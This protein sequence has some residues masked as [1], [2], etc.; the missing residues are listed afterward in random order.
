MNIFIHFK[1]AETLNVEEIID[2]LCE[3]SYNVS[4]EES[5]ENEGVS[6]GEN[7]RGDVGGGVLMDPNT[8]AIVFLK[9]KAIY[10][11]Q[12]LIRESWIWLEAIY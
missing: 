8:D 12:L 10:P 6:G 11:C 4:G 1:M 2:V 7:E 3:G 9:T 5:V